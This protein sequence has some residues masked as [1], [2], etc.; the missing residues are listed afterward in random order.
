MDRKRTTLLAQGSY[1]VATGAAPFV[2]RRAFERV[3]GPKRDWWL[4]ET[5]GVL[6]TAVG[7]GLMSAAVSDRVTPE[8]ELIAAGCAAGLAAIDLVHVARRRIA[9]TYLVDAA[10]ELAVLVALSSSDGP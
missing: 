6:V 2:S 4:V 10:V 9:P 5:V 8:I 7:A 3:T 1:Y